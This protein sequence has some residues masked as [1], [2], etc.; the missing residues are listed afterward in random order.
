M[1]EETNPD[2]MGL[3]KFVWWFGI[4][5]NRFDPLNLGRCKVRCFG[6]HTHKQSEIGVDDLP[7][8]HPVVPYGGKAVQPPPEGSMVFGFFADGQEGRHPIVMG[9]IPGIPEEL[10]S[11]TSGFSDPYSEL[12]KA[13]NT[14]P[15]FPRRV[16]SSSITTDAS[17]PRIENDVAK[18]YPTYLNEPTVS[19][20]ARPNRIESP[21]DGSSLG[22]RSESIQGT[23]IDF[24]RRNR[25]TNVKSAKSDPLLSTEKQRYQTTW[26]EP[27][28]SFNPRYPFNNVTETE[29]GH[30][31]ELDDTP[32]FERVQLSHRTGSTLE[33]LPS[34]SV[35]QKTFNNKYDVTMGN[36]KSYVNGTK[37][38]TVQSDMFL[39]ING[40]LVIQ[41]DGIDFESA[42][43]INMKGFNIKITADNKLDIFSHLTTRVYGGAGLEM[44]TEGKLATYG[45][46]GANHGSGGLT[47]ISGTLNPIAQAVREAIMATAEKN[48]L[49][50]G[51][52][53]ELKND[54]EAPNVLNSGVRVSGGNFWI[55]TILTTFNS[56]V[57]NILP[58]TLLEPPQG[59]G[60]RVAK[61][62]KAPVP[63]IKPTSPTSRKEPTDS[64]AFLEQN[65]VQVEDINNPNSANTQG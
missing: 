21:E 39:K 48:G 5:E 45:G 49:S 22:V 31:F 61:K 9:I 17:G 26:N 3:G 20:L 64:M 32:D 1:E 7:W 37:E 29:S 2:F 38:E 24:Q 58:P 14:D 46:S 25:V 51:Q 12:E 43:D 56:A 47:D 54:I 42:G 50:L 4:V 57:T 19:R 65:K 18:R 59:R 8:A 16:A 44:R 23:T 63:K 27:F 55:N 53:E 62:F 11:E 28:P 33:F 41:C 34:G 30:A 36:H 40:K 52:K 35:K 6:W 10:R 60:A 15:L 13:F